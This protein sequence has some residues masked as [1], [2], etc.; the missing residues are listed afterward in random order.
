VGWADI[1]LQQVK[2]DTLSPTH[3]WGQ[4]ATFLARALVDLVLVSSLLQAVS[5]T[6]RN[7][8]QKALYASRQINR[9]DE[10]VEREEIRRAVARPKDQWF[11]HGLDFRHYDKE[12]LR[13]LHSN[14]SDR[15]RKEFIDKIFAQSG[16]S[17]G[18][19][20]RIL[21]ELA[22]RRA[23]VEELETALSAVRVE[24]DTNAHRI[25]PGDFSDIFDHLRSI[26]GLRD[27]K[28]DLLDFA[29]K[30]GA[31]EERSVPKDFA[32]LLEQ[33]IFTSRRDQFIYTRIHA[34]KALTNIVP[35]L[36]DRNDLGAMLV[37]LRM[38]RKE[39]FGASTFVPAKLEEAL[40]KR[41]KE[42][43]PP[44]IGDEGFWP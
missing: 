41:L 3:P 22:R 36:D 44:L 37:N 12:R 6:L 4:H 18:F 35:R 31:F 30:I 14:T 17:V 13:E 19:S 5:I 23:R 27:F 29:E 38:K 2:F 34:A 9:L 42:I 43:G 20:I 24:H 28:F 39:L 21:E 25:Q 33:I 40:E 32:D 7:R 8:Q 11:K 10:L 1:Y 15:R 16:Q 26:E